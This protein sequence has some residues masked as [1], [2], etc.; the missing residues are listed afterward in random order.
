MKNRNPRWESLTLIGIVAGAAL[1]ETAY[2]PFS[3]AA[4]SWL[5][6]LW[7]VLFYGAAGL[8]TA[9]NSAALERA[10]APRDCVGRPIM[11]ADPDL[12]APDEDPTPSVARPVAHS[13][14]HSEAI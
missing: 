5:L 9:Q 1:I 8:W 3:P 12:A 10:A 13:L 7:I 4:E 11:T 14:S 6:I 2:L